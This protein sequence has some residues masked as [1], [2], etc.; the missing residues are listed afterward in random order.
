MKKIKITK[1]ICSYCGKEFN[2]E[3]QCIEC[4]SFHE[5]PKRICPP[6]DYDVSNKKGAIAY[7]KTIKIEMV[8][9]NVG[10]YKYIDEIKVA[11]EEPE[12]PETE[13]EEEA[14]PTAEFSDI[15]ENSETNNNYFEENTNTYTEQWR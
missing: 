1:F 4:E 12:T 14:I 10:I 6:E 9:G 3:E 11:E 13:N 8:S 15:N 5:K 2:E 7:P